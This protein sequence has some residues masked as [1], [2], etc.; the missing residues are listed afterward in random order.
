M[1]KRGNHDEEPALFPIYI[2]IYLKSIW[3][4]MP[5]FNIDFHTPIKFSPVKNNT[6]IELDKSSPVE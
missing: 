4:S 1:L 6:R 5:I 2:S 3:P